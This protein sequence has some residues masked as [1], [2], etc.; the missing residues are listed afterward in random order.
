MS[1][2]QE[3]ASSRQSAVG[4]RQAPPA[5]RSLRSGVGG[6]GGGWCP[7]TAG[8]PEACLLPQLLLTDDLAE[9]GAQ[10][11]AVGLVRVRPARVS[12][13]GP[14]QRFTQGAVVGNHPLPASPTSFHS[15][16]E[17]PCSRRSAVGSRQEKSCP[18]RHL[19]NVA[20]EGRGLRPRQSGT[21]RRAGAVT[22]RPRTF[23]RSSNRPRSDRRH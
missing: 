23:L 11:L 13:M 10:Q 12:T 5:E 21:S 16:G 2:R 7:P 19:G 4:S 20:L 9:S 3:A 8:M 15:V 14:H 1:S 22:S 17:E 18:G 6:V